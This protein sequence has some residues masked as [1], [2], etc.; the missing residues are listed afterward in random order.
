MAKPRSPE[1]VLRRTSAHLMKPCSSG[2]LG[3]D[4]NVALLGAP[5]YKCPPGLGG[6]RR[7][8][9]TRENNQKAQSSITW[10]KGSEHGNLSIPNWRHSLLC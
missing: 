9:G 3:L 1:A 5:N 2:H 7:A 8:V 4:S 6:F 10:G